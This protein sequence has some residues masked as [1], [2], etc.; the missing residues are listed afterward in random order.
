MTSVLARGGGALIRV[1]L[2]DL[3]HILLNLRHGIDQPF[4]LNVV[5][6]QLCLIRSVSILPCVR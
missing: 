5:R 1:D 6:R 2:P 3:K 4:Q